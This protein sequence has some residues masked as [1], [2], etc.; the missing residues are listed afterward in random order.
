MYFLPM[1]YIGRIPVCGG[2]RV[3]DSPISPFPYGNE[4]FVRKMAGSCRCPKLQ[5][6]FQFSLNYQPAVKCLL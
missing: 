4:I 5:G 1:K 6:L 3:E 2:G